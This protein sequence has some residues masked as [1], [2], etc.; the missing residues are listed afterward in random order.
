MKQTIIY[1]VLAICFIMMMFGIIVYY[2]TLIGKLIVGIA[3]II[4]CIACILSSDLLLKD[5]E[6]EEA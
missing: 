5:D 6:D 1:C 4:A 2:L 3:A